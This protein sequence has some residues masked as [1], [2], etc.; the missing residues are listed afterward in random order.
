MKGTWVKG[1]GVS[2]FNKIYQSLGPLNIIAEDLGE[3][4]PEVIALRDTLDFPGMKILQFAF[5]GDKKNS[6]LPYNY[7][8]P[9]SVIYTGTHDNDTTVG[10]FLSDKL[11]DNR[12]KAIKHQCNRTLRDDNEINK[13]LIYLAL[14][15][16]SRLAIFPLQDILGF[17]S[18]CKM[19]SP[20]TKEGNWAWRCAPRFLTSEIS[21]WLHEQCEQFGRIPEKE[22]KTKEK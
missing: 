2:F 8:T 21:G 9:N 16:I 1:P 20:G 14:S 12:R 4:T 5:D 3:I 6:F 17:G 15:S 7:T 10:W 19:N 13:D 18:D 11:D 22:T